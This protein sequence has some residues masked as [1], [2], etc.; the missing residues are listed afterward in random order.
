MLVASEEYNNLPRLCWQCLSQSTATIRFIKTTLERQTSDKTPPFRQS[1]QS[2]GRPISSSPNK[3]KNRDFSLS[4]QIC[5]SSL[6][7]FDPN[8]FTSRRPEARDSHQPLSNFAGVASRTSH[9]ISSPG[10]PLLSSPLCHSQL[11]SSISLSATH[12]NKFS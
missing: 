11:L 2:E 8:C 12:V 9:E 5:L 10:L 1:C 3:Y 4:F 6:S 7:L